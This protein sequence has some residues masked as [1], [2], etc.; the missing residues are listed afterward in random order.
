MIPDHIFALSH[1]CAWDFGEASATNCYC[2]GED[3]SYIEM[4]DPCI[5]T[6]ANI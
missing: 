3:V 2:F 5:V 4:L 6:T 1:F